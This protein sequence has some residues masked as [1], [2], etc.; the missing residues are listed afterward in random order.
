MSG[1]A[2]AGDYNSLPDILPTEL[3]EYP[4]KEF[5]A[6][7]CDIGRIFRSRQR[8]PNIA[9]TLTELEWETELKFVRL[10]REFFGDI[11]MVTEEH[12]NRLGRTIPGTGPI[13]AVL[14][15][16]DGS[17]S[18]M[19]GSPRYTC[20]MAV[21]KHGSPIFGLVYRPATEEVFLAVAGGGA[22]RGRE[23]LYAPLVSRR[24]PLV[25]VKSQIRD[26]PEVAALTRRLRAAGYHTERMESTSLK[27]CWTAQRRRAGI[28]KSLRS[29]HGVLCDWGTAAGLLIC[30]EAGLRPLTLDGGMWRPA[31]GGLM[32][33]EGPHAAHAAGL[34]AERASDAR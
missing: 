10:F 26:V 33:G 3:S 5:V 13:S 24:S 22:Y 12:M 2:T 32:V 1:A 21:K 11:P 8:D 29:R 15:P 30:Q 23:R 34:Y 27:L 16:L 20:T 7:F 31:T 18:Y 25:S 14:D 28:V 17:L 6:M 9:S 4:L 19:S